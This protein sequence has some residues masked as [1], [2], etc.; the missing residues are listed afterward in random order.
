[1]WVTLKTVAFASLHR[2]A[3]AKLGNWVLRYE[4]A[5]TESTCELQNVVV[6][7]GATELHKFAQQYLHFPVVLITEFLFKKSLFLGTHLLQTS[8]CKYSSSFS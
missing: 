8:T 2:A 3:F 4:V 6:N 1:M 7:F 5:N